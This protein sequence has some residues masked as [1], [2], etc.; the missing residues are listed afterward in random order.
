MSQ[1]DRVS[2]FSLRHLHI[3]YFTRRPLGNLGQLGR[4]VPFF[5]S[6]TQ[7][8]CTTDAFVPGTFSVGEKLNIR[9][10]YGGSDVNS[11]PLERAFAY[12]YNPEITSVAP[13]TTILS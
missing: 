7:L 12:K 11:R 6:E 1:S 10:L 8:T 3:N 5:R 13:L 9:M 4:L 2:N